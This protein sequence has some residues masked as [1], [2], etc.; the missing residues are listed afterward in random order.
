[1]LKILKQ[2]IPLIIIFF[3]IFYFCFKIVDNQLNKA[4]N[5]SSDYR[6]E[7]SLWK[8]FGYSKEPS[9]NFSKFAIYPDKHNIRVEYKI[10][11]ISDNP[12]N[13]IN[14]IDLTVVDSD[15]KAGDPGTTLW[16]WIQN[17]EKRNIKNTNLSPGNVYSEE[18]IINRQE[19]NANG[20]FYINAYYKGELVSQYKIIEMS[21]VYK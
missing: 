9:L 5:N 10:E 18:I 8:E 2:P 4:F 1:M 14:E 3:L 13:I 6:N 20:Q 17:S 15:S 11:N 19:A 21:D 12:V 7:I 16:R